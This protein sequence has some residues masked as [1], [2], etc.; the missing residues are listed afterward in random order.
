MLILWLLVCYPELSVIAGLKAYDE[1]PLAFRRDP[2]RFENRA[3]G[4]QYWLLDYSNCE[5]KAGVLTKCD[6]KYHPGSLPSERL[7]VPFIIFGRL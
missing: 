3:I 6:S 7:V 4:I 1:D 5:V 2:C